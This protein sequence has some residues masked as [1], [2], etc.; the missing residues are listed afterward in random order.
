MLS[1]E[2]LKK[3]NHFIYRINETTNPKTQWTTDVIIEDTDRG[4]HMELGRLYIENIRLED[5]D[6]LVIMYYNRMFRVKVTDDTLLEVIN[7]SSY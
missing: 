4:F 3:V 2:S 6:T 7:Q 5:D 1:K